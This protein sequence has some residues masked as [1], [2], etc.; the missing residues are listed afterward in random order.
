MNFYLIEFE[1]HNF[2]DQWIKYIRLV[3]AHNYERACEKI[4]NLAGEEWEYGTPHKFIDLT[5]F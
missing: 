4:S 1:A 5:I 3:F 2:Q